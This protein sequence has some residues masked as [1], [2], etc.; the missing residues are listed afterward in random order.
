MNPIKVE[1]VISKIT[2]HKNSNEDIAKAILDTVKS[3]PVVVYKSKD[4]K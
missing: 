3:K 2:L 4:F 1:D